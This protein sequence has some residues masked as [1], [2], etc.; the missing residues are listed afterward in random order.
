[1]ISMTDD[2]KQIEKTAIKTYGKT[3]QTVVAIEEMSE[4]IKELSKCLR[5][6]ESKGAITEEIA[7]VYI[8]IDQVMMMYG[9]DL[10][11]VVT[12]MSRKLERLKERMEIY[13]RRV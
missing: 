7:D 8:M 3:I 10:N 9:I 4:L 1:M 13:E 5:G 11:E 12:V 6:Y 2:E